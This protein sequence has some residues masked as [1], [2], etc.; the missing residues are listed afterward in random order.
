MTE[1]AP[2]REM[3]IVWSLLFLGSATI[4]VALLA[5]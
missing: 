4:W 1:T 3:A 2:R 5:V